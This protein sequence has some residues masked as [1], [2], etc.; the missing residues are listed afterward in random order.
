MQRQIQAGETNSANAFGAGTHAVA[1]ARA[2]ARAHARTV[3]WCTG[4]RR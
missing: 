1:R 3:S 4:K 2:G